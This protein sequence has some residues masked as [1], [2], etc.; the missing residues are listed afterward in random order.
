LDLSERYSRLDRL[1]HRVAFATAG[2]Q[3]ELADLEDRLFRREL[4]GI[5]VREPVFITSLPRAGT[6]TLLQV[7]SV[8]DEFACHT[9]RDMPFL[10]LPLLWDRL[11]RGFRKTDAPTERA[12]GDGVLV[13]L[14]SAEAFEEMLWKARWP[15]QY[16]GDRIIP[17]RSGADAEFIRTFNNH[18][19]KIILLRRRDPDARTRY[20]SKN[21]GNIARLGF[22]TEC[23]PDALIVVPVREPLQHAASLLQQHVRFLEI[24]ARDR[25]ARDYMR[26]VGHLEFGENLRPVDFDGWLAS[27]RHT[28]PRTIEFWLEYWVAAYEHFLN[29]HSSIIRFFAYDAFCEAPAAG[30]RTLASRINAANPDALV[31]Q[32]HDIHP[33]RRHEVQSAGLDETLMSRARQA[34]GQVL[35]QAR[36]EG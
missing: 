25:F 18:L 4:A 21:N 11:S 28:D 23:C 2:P 14:D 20:V 33:P 15:E 5:E 1:V 6:T 10:L 13:S 17:W 22:L 34:Y 16:R 9:Y 32:Q 36:A 7:C 29:R 3:F 30:L 27:A 12:H 26:G 19:R 35:E 8:L 24:H 31:A